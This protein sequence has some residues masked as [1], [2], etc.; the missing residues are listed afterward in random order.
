MEH[1]IRK[2]VAQLLFCAKIRSADVSTYI[3]LAS[4]SAITIAQFCP[5]KHWKLPAC[6]YLGA[7]VLTIG[8]IVVTIGAFMLT[9]GVFSYH[10]RGGPGPERHLNA[11]RQT[12]REIIFAAQLLRNYV[13]NAEIVGINS[14]RILWI[15]E[16]WLSIQLW[17]SKQFR[18]CKRAKPVR[19]STVRFQF[20]G[21]ICP[22]ISQQKMP[23]QYCSRLL[24]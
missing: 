20:L 4:D 22:E 13:C 23:K 14:S 9:I 10:P 15:L 3:T 21:G 1:F 16:F 18:T 8:A 24:L 2:F 7:F 11:A 5:S 6:K 17:I 12:C 19:N